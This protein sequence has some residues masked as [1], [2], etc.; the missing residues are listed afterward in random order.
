MIGFNKIIQDIGLPD[1]E[2]LK[3]FSGPAPPK[4]VGKCIIETETRLNVNGADGVVA[5]QEI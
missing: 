4:Y 1:I 5:T 3:V 2:K